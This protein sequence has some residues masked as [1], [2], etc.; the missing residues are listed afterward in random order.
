[1]AVSGLRVEKST[2]NTAAMD[3]SVSTLAGW[4][5]STRWIVRVLSPLAS[6]SCCWDQPRF[7]RSFWISMS[8]PRCGMAAI[9]SARAHRYHATGTTA[10]RQ[11]SDRPNENR[12]SG[13]DHENKSQKQGPSLVA[14]QGVV[15]R[16][17]YAGL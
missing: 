3:F 15:V 14:A 5:A 4:P 16:T 10:Q 2:S 8:P 6:A 1:M 17:D 7:S 12:E 11:G 9:P 13:T